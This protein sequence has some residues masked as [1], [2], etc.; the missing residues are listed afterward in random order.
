MKKTIFRSLLDN[1]RKH[2]K[3]IEAEI[4][5]INKKSVEL[6]LQTAEK[7]GEIK[8]WKEKNEELKRQRGWSDI[9]DEEMK[10]L[11]DGN[12]QKYWK[13]GTFFKVQPTQRE[14]KEKYIEVTGKK[15]ELFLKKWENSPELEIK[16][17]W[18]DRS[19]KYYGVGLA[20]HNNWAIEYLNEKFGAWEAAI[21]IT[22]NGESAHT[23]L[24]KAGW[25]RVMAW[26][27][28]F[29]KYIIPTK[30]THAQKQT[31]YTYCKLHKETLPFNDPLFNK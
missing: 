30:L 11:M 14:I 9:T 10:W 17:G 23:Y 4:V 1:L 15:D 31:L 20:E 12:Y 21:K 8:V 27:R 26:P 22:N 3:N 6:E 7:R 29:V 24:E 5:L 16:N 18:I 28:M 25:V 13:D 2:I 19:G